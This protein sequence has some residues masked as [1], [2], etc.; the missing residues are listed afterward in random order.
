VS[1]S[2]GSYFEGTYDGYGKCGC[3]PVA[4]GGD[5]PRLV[6]ASDDKKPSPPPSMY[7]PGSS[8]TVCLA[9]HVRSGGGDLTGSSIIA[10]NLV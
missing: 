7:G 9:G 5:E 2:T 3:R 10:A 4:G 8:V 1:R 6:A